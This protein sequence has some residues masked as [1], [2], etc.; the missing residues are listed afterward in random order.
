MQHALITETSERRS[1]LTSL[2]QIV[3]EKKSPGLV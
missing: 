2:E 3:Q 1:L